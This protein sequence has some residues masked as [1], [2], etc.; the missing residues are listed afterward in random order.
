MEEK[1]EEKRSIGTTPQAPGAAPKINRMIVKKIVA[2]FYR[3]NGIH[4]PYKNRYLF[5]TGSCIYL[6]R[7]RKASPSMV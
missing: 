2:L 3:E 7:K 1:R 4:F 6:F 5:R